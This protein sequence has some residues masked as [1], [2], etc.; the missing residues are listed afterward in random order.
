M[1]FNPVVPMPKKIETI[2]ARDITV[3][4]SVYLNEGGNYVEYLVVNQGIPSNS[5]LYDSSCN[6]T[7]LLRKDVH[8]NRVWNTSDVNIYETSAINT[9]L[10]SDFFN[11]LGAVEQTIIRQVKIPYR[12]NGG[13]GGTNQSG[14]NGLSCKIFLLSGYEV[15]W[16]TSDNQHFPQDGAKLD[17]FESG[18]DTS[19]NNKRIAY[20]SIIK[21]LWLL[22]SP[23][24]GNTSH[25][26]AVEPGGGNGA[27]YA[28]DEESIRPALILPFNAEFDKTNMRLIGIV[29][30]QI[31]DYPEGSVIKINE[32][33][34]PVNFYVAKHNYESALNGAGRTLVVRKDVYDQHVWRDPTSSYLGYEDST[35]DAWLNNTYKTLFDSATQA[36]IGTTDFR[37][38][39]TSIVK[40]SIFLLSVAELAGPGYISGEGDKLNIAD[41]LQIAYKDGVATTQ[42]TRSISTADRERAH[43]LHSNG[44]VMTDKTDFTNGSRPC[45]TL[46]ANTKVDANGLIIT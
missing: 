2:Q 46:P 21:A 31:S 9:W 36:L 23:Y 17:Y 14:A 13:L 42:W 44:S 11:S 41:M 35:I 33:G 28:S 25:V 24:T 26:W 22:R 32:N 37:V 4:S 16:T 40:R 1:I 8:S 12:K 29:D 18:T 3:G 27:F 10:N 38:Y 39:S 45:F 15:G 7:W 43:Y 5:S 34:S 19:A 6:G 20:L 30:L